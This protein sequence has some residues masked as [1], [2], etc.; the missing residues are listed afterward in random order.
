[1]SFRNDVVPVLT[2]A[3]CNAGACHGAADGKNGFGLSL[4]G[5][6]PERDHRALT[7]EYR[8][9]RLSPADPAASLVLAKPTGAVRH[10]GGERLE[11]DGPHVALLRRWIGEGAR[12][13]GKEARALV[14]LAVEPPELVLGRG[15]QVPLVVTATYADG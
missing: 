1:V 8:G 4:F 2:R 9:R 11:R 3:G 10:K 13:D 15:Q 14:G 12:D 5:Y 6:D 7:R